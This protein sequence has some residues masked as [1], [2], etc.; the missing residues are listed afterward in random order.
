MAPAEGKPV[1]V[2][3]YIRFRNGINE[4]VREHGRSKRRWF[5]WGGKGALQGVREARIEN[6]PPAGAGGL[7]LLRIAQGLERSRWARRW[8]RVSP[9]YK[10]GGRV[11]RTGLSFTRLAPRQADR[12]P[13]SGLR[14]GCIHDGDDPGPLGVA[15]L[16]GLGLADREGREVAHR[17]HPI[18]R[19]PGAFSAERLRDRQGGRWSRSRARWQSQKPKQPEGRQGAAQ[20]RRER[21][22][23]LGQHRRPFRG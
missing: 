9:A 10:S 11:K 23:R 12:P 7:E 8:E 16:Q 14:G 21:L 2:R 18:S 1:R 22:G 19:R 20:R 6:R 13:R 17:Q 3:R 15:E 5:R 4:T